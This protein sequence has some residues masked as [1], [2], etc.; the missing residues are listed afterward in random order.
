MDMT[1]RNGRRTKPTALLLWRLGLALALLIATPLATQATQST[2]ASPVHAA[3]ACRDCV[4]LVG[5]TATGSSTPYPVNSPTSVPTAGTGVQSFV[6]TALPPLLACWRAYAQ[7]STL[8]DSAEQ[9][10]SA[11][12]GPS[13]DDWLQYLGAPQHACGQA[14][15]ALGAQLVPPLRSL[16]LIARFYAVSAQTLQAAVA[17]VTRLIQILNTK[18]QCTGSPTSCEGPINGAIYGQM[19]QDAILTGFVN[20]LTLANRVIHAFNIVMPPVHG[21]SEQFSPLSGDFQAVACP[22]R[23]VCYSVGDQGM[24]YGRGT[25]VATGDGGATWS[26]QANGIGAPFTGLACPNTTTCYAVGRVENRAATALMAT[27]DGSAHWRSQSVPTDTVLNS[28]ACPSATT[29]YAV[30]EMSNGTVV[31]THD[32]GAHWRRQPTPTV[33]VLYSIACPTLTTCYVV[34]D[35]DRRDYKATIMTTRDGGAHWRRS[36]L[37]ARRDST[38]LTSIACPNAT[39]CYALGRGNK[40][41]IVTR[42]GG[43]HWRSQ[44]TPTD[45]VLNSIACPSATTC[46]A[47][48]HAVG[49]VFGDLLQMSPK[50]TVVVT[51]DGGAHWRRQRS[52]AGYG[53]LYGIACPDTLTVYAVGQYGI[54]LAATNGGNEQTATPTAT[55]TL[56]P[57][58]ATAT[59]PSPSTTPP[60]STTARATATPTTVIATPTT[61]IATIPAPSVTTMATSTATPATPTRRTGR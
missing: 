8:V 24:T 4:D 38:I 19:T 26:T 23:Q 28:I 48:G 31:V 25:I 9:S 53:D 36:S 59:M 55:V 27:R 56:T 6:Q 34:G 50:G 21:W 29:C 2:P 22:S 10:D 47:V 43:V 20:V 18:T 61:V 37:A 54:I 46:Y 60:P 32:G 17:S 7:L 57:I 14:R 49:P 1:P 13:Y 44:S 5:P 42:D 33:A 51:H 16:P 45:T 12:G 40:D 15:Q 11:L 35:M 52:P 30:G 41:T 39:T 3:G 58:T